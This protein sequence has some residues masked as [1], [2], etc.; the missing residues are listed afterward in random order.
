MYRVV[1]GMVL[2]LALLAGMAG[3]FASPAFAEDGCCVMHQIGSTPLYVVSKDPDV[4]TQKGCQE[5]D[6]WKK[7]VWMVDA[8]DDKCKQTCIE[9]FSNNKE[10]VHLY[11]YDPTADVKKK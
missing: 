8:T 3:G 7:T 1:M 4:T 10:C 6:Y 5:D 11:D 2:S 9:S